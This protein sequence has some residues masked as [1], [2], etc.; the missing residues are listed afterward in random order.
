VLRYRKKINVINN[1]IF[2]SLT[3]KTEDFQ[4]RTSTFL[5]NMSSKRYEMK[6]MMLHIEPFCRSKLKRYNIL[7]N[8]TKDSIQKFSRR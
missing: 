6:K 7:P 1:L 4:N 2:A 5:Q 8:L 3:K